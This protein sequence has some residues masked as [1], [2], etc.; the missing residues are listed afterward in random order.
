MTMEIGSEISHKIRSAIKAK[1]VELGAYVD[2]ELPDYIMVMV[3]NKK[4]SLQMKE[5]LNLFL[6]GN[7]EKFTTWLHNLINKLQSISSETVSD[8]KEKEKKE[9]ERKKSTEKKKFATID[10]PVAV[11]VKKVEKAPAVQKETVKPKAIKVKEVVVQKEPSPAPEPE[12][13]EFTVRADT[14]EFSEEM[15]EIEKQA[16]AKRVPSQPTT[17]APPVVIPTPKVVVATPPPAPV[18]VVREPPVVRPAASAV[19][20]LSDRKPVARPEA[21]RDG[22]SVVSSDKPTTVVR[23]TMVM[24][25]SSIALK[26]KAPSSVVK[27]M[28]S[29]A[30]EE[31]EYDPHNP[32]VGSVASVVRV[33]ARKSSVPRS[34]QANKMLLM[35]AMTDA[36]KSVTTTGKRSVTVADTRQERGQQR[37]QYNSSR[38]TVPADNN[39]TRSYNPTRPS[40]VSRSKKEEIMRRMKYTIEVESPQDSPE[41]PGSEEE[42]VPDNRVV[43]VDPEEEQDQGVSSPEAVAGA[44]D[45]DP[46]IEV[47]TVVEEEDGVGGGVEEETEQEAEAIPVIL[48]EEASDEFRHVLDTEV[49]A[50]SQ[51]QGRLQQ[52][53]QEVMAEEEG[54][55]NSRVV[56]DNSKNTKFIVTLDGVDPDQYDSM[57]VDMDDAAADSTRVMEMMSRVAPPRIKPF[58]INLKDSDDEEDPSITPLKKAKMAEKCR[59]WPACVNGNAC[60]Y[61]HPTVTCKTFPSCKF[62][63]KCLYIHPNCKYDARCTKTDCPFTHASRRKPMAISPPQVIAIPQPKVILAAPMAAVPAASTHPRQITCRFFP[64]CHNMKCP[65]KHPKPCRYG[66]SCAKKA[67]CPFFHPALPSKDKL[68][69]KAGKVEQGSATN[70]DGIKAS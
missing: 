24:K 31:E 41:E 7:T 35:K 17:T 10:V 54:D 64:N 46:G 12:E 43:E 51:V 23:R 28:S 8:D 33:T 55:G 19:S 40:L 34:L 6:G 13:P 49:G 57:E 45:S 21:R 18:T 59:F 65:F 22:R 42:L 16:E 25:S 39:V 47:E 67:A 66:L 14:D 36:E 5:D 2:E 61:H 62:G 70:T 50:V 38:G 63:D 20:R 58:S 3:A 68:T 30:E 4:N 1:L 15:K 11:P 69:W 60:E 27:P 56:K 53:Q 26:R 44:S 52:Q 48:E 29:P 9:K 32:S 37:S